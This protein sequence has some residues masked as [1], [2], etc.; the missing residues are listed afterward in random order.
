MELTGINVLKVR[1]L[2]GEF[3]YKADSKLAGKQYRRFTTGG[4]VF[5]S[6]D[7]TFFNELANGGL[8]TVSLEANE[9]G[10]LSL[11]DFITWKQ[12]NGLKR[13]QVENEGITLKNYKPQSVAQLEE[14]S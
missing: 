5:I 14:L 6:N 4:K 1:A 7:D 12:V 13:N 9:E 2:P 3:D 11:T 8:H 10:Q